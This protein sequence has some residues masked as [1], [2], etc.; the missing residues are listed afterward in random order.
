VAIFADDTVA[1]QSGSFYVG[2]VAPQTA[3]TAA[4][5]PLKPDKVKQPAAPPRDKNQRRL[6]KVYYPV[7][8]M[9]SP[10]KP[11]PTGTL[12][13]KAKYAAPLRQVYA[14]IKGRQLPLRQNGAIW[15]TQYVLPAQSQTLYIQI[16]AEDAQ[17]NLSMTEKTLKY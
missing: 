10:A 9:L 16:Y 8:I 6:N 4:A 3:P 11:Q 13:I 17:G 2:T 1:E 15:Q 5:A 14:R 7:E 12:T